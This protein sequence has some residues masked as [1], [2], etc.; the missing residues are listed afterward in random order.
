MIWGTGIDADNENAY[1]PEKWNGSNLLGFALTEVRE[2][3]KRIR[4][5]ENEV[6]NLQDD[7]A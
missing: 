5:Y 4:K 3:I 2:E 1:H 7:D 6:L